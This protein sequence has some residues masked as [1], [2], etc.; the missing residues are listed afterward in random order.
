MYLR[1]KRNKSGSISVQI[2]SKANRKYKVLKTIG[3]AKTEQE[4]QRLYYLGKQ[5]IERLS[6]QTKLFVSETDTI[7]DSIFQSLNNSSIRVV[8]PELIFENIFD[9]ITPKT[10]TF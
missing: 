7:I 5:E 6:S 4:V 1:K 3:C 9:I 8:G 10:G 2:I